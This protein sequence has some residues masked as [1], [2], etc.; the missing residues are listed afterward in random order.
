MSLGRRKPS[1]GLSP[2]TLHGEAR[3]TSQTPCARLHRTSKGAWPPIQLDSDKIIEA[4]LFGPINDR[5]IMPPTSEEEAVLLGNEPELQEALELPH[6]PLNIPK[7]RNQR[8]QLSS[9]ILQVHL[10]LHPWPQTPRVTGPRIPGEPAI[11]LE[12]SICRSLTQTTPT[13]GSGHT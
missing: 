11:G 1:L 6:L 12:L 13:T 8:N 7:S 4:S 5:P 2:S 10:P 9:L 3:D